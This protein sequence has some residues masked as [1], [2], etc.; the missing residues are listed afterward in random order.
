MGKALDIRGPVNANTAYCD[1]KLV[2]RNVTLTLPEVTHVL[3]TI[4]TALGPQDIP[5]YGLVESMQ[6]TIQK[7]GVDKGLA[8]I[9]AL[10][11]K[12]IEFRWSQQVT[13]TNGKIATEGCKA[14]LRFIPQVVPPVE[15]NPGDNVELEIPGSVTRY[16]LYCDGKEL[17]LIDKLAGICKINGVDYAKQL[18]SLL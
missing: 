5:L 1:G 8:R 2:A 14:F 18:D 7:I 15:I 17:I 13:K 10:K 4:N 3:A 11:S 16:Q 6:A 9:C 12:T